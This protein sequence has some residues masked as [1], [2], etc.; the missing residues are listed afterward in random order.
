MVEYLKTK[1]GYFYK[2]KKNGEKKRISQE[3]YNKKKTRHIRNKRTKN[4]RGGTIMT[5]HNGVTTS[6]FDT[7]TSQLKITFEGKKGEELLMFEGTLDL[8]NPSYKKGVLNIYTE[9]DTLFSS[10]TGELHDDSKMHELKAHGQGKCDWYNTHGKL[11][12]SHDG[13]WVNDKM[14]GEGVSTWYDE[15][16]RVRKKIEGVWSDDG[17]WINKKDGKG[18]ETLYDENGR[19]ESTV[20]GVLLKGKLHGHCKSDWYDTHGKL[21]QSHDGMWVNDKM[22]GEGVSTWYNENGSVHSTLQ[23]VWSDDGMWVNKKDGKGLF[24]YYDENGRVKSTIEGVFLKGNLHDE[25]F[26]LHGKGFSLH[27]KGVAI[28]Y[29]EH[30]HV[31]NKSVIMLKPSAIQPSRVSQQV[32]LLK[33]LAIQPQRVPLLAPPP[34]RNKKALLEARRRELLNV[35]DNNN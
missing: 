3:E 17:M 24:T 2:L 30:G 18:L 12:K 6:S 15:N 27:G 5:Q 25:G 32:P 28:W 8:E 20:Q 21:F 31:K 7:E 33:P 1:K 29:D 16:G 35:S 34:S 4:A 10:Y 26:S 9:N 22:D 23:G 19:V 13:M 11:V 14:D